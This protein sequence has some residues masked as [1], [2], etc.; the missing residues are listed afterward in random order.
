MSF[1]RATRIRLCLRGALVF[2]PL[3]ALFVSPARAGVDHYDL[4]VEPG[5]PTSITPFDVVVDG[6]G[7]DVF[8]GTP[9]DRLVLREGDTIRVV[10]SHGRLF[11]CSEVPGRH[12]WTI[13]PF[14]AGAYHLQLLAYVGSPDPET[15]VELTAGIDISIAPSAVRPAV[16]PALSTGARLGLAVL[17][18]LVGGLLLIRLR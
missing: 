1:E 11:H 18:A 8:S 7:C 3:F 10:V 15:A 17:L 2:A 12:R 13:G 16:V 5:S 6:D 4:R 9:S 14:P